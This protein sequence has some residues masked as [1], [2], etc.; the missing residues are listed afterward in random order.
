MSEGSNRTIG[1][2]TTIAGFVAIASGVLTSLLPVDTSQTNYPTCG[3]VLVQSSAEFE[4]SNSLWDSLDTSYFASLCA[5]ELETMRNWAIAF[6]VFGILLITVGL[7]VLGRIA[8]NSNRA[9]PI[10]VPVPS[11]GSKG[12]SLS[13]QLASIAKLHKEG[14]LTSE[15]YSLAKAH[16]LDDHHP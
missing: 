11:E 4:S 10:S 13:E 3:S 12:P 8:S 14:S 9:V 5:T 7:V 16:T 15:E 1:I 2:V 6:G